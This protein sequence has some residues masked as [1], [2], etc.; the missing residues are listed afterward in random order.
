MAKSE[1]GHW[2]QDIIKINEKYDL[3]PTPHPYE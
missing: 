3:K 1:L 2:F